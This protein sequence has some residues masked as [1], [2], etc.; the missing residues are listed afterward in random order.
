MS[1]ESGKLKDQML[2]V[3]DNLYCYTLLTVLMIFQFIYI[4]PTTG[5][6]QWVK[7][8]PRKRVVGCSNSCRDRPKSLK[9]VV[10][11]PMLNTRQ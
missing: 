2:V 4:P 1:K 11:A 8:S 3:I 10:T 5:V 6:A 9:Q 7:R